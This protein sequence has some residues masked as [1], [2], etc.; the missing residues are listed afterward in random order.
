MM[1]NLIQSPL[2]EINRRQEARQTLG[3]WHELQQKVH[4]TIFKTENPTSQ[5]VSGLGWSPLPPLSGTKN[6]YLLLKKNQSKIK[7]PTKPPPATST[8]YSCCGRH[9]ALSTL[10]RLPHKLNLCIAT[11]I[12]N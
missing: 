7:N 4:M 1:L 2:K 12:N 9:T 10:N 11:N 8:S 5:S 3:L 6:I